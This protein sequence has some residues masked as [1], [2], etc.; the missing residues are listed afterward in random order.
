MTTRAS[1][2]LGVVTSAVIC[3]AASR[4]RMRST[5]EVAFGDEGEA[6]RYVS[7]TSLVP[8]TSTLQPAPRS[9]S[10]S[11]MI[12]PKMRLIVDESNRDTAP[13]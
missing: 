7:A 6:T 3:A 8:A 5:S 10:D 9:A 12:R 4:A 1:L 11:S 13:G 2:S